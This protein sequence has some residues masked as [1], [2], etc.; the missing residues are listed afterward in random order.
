MFYQ[1][2]GKLNLS[3][4]D[5]NRWILPLLG[6]AYGIC[7]Y[8]L[9]ENWPDWGQ[10]F[11]LSLIMFF[12]VFGAAGL[13]FA[14]PLGLRRAA[15]VSAALASLNALLMLWVSFG[16]DHVGDG[17]FS[18]TGR[19]WIATVLVPMPFILGF[20][21]SP[22]RFWDYDYL[23][24]TAWGLFARYVLSGLFAS[25]GF[26]ILWG[27]AAAMKL[28]GI[29]LLEDIL[30]LEE[31][32][33]LILGA[34]FGLSVAVLYEVEEIVAA[35]LR[36]IELLLRALLPVIVVFSTIFL[37]LLFSKLGEVDRQRTFFF[38][39]SIAGFYGAMLLAGIVF[40]T[41]ACSIK[42]RE[43]KNSIMVWMCRAMAVN[44]GILALLVL[45]AAMHRVGQY[46]WTPDRLM[47]CLLAL[48]GLIYGLG[49][50]A[51]L[52]WKHD[53]WAKLRQVN[54]FAGLFAVLV[55]ILWLTPVLDAHRISANSQEARVLAQSKGAGSIEKSLERW[56]RAGT[57]SLVRLQQ[58]P[59]AAA[60]LKTSMSPAELQMEK[61]LDR[62]VYLN[63]EEFIRSQARD[64]NTRLS[65]D[66]RH[67][68]GAYDMTEHNMTEHICYVVH[69]DTT[70]VDAS[71]QILVFSF[72]NLNSSK[73][74]GVNIQ[75]LYTRYNT[76]DSEHV[77][78][79]TGLPIEIKALFAQLEQGQTPLVEVVTP[80]LQI[81]NKA[82]QISKSS[83]ILE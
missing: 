10:R 50:T 52:F 74:I 30:Q 47:L 71:Q 49:Y 24:Q 41:A 53:W 82:Y 3:N 66:L 7:F 27:F 51:A 25:I 42:G 9:T 57:E 18:L 16:F 14:V 59:A 58:N 62:I 31:A 5:I 65:G 13:M 46:G 22:N 33:F 21:Q 72:S 73:N 11:W 8:L 79:I 55:G 29:Y 48:L 15:L 20:M 1:L 38:G 4:V 83:L 56:G 36:M 64:P 68:C 2:L 37:I 43:T 19:V 80:A 23:Y 78:R 81:G 40:L 69:R 54:I 32:M 67:A 76:W 28:V 77:V 75:T 60:F 44:S 35:A 39:N 6:G 63:G 17:I 61:L 70:P 45:W 26:G 34:L 12:G